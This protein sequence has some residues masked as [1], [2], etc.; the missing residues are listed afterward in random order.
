MTCLERRED[1]KGNLGKQGCQERRAWMEI[2]DFLG[3]KGRME[4]QVCQ[5]SKADM[6]N[7]VF[8]VLM[9]QEDLQGLEAHMV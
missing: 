4:G 3:R 1:F 9:D 5:V 6:E 2:L 8:Q 7:Q